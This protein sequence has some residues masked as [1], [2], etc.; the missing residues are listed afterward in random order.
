MTRIGLLA[1]GVPYCI[2]QYNGSSEKRLRFL[3]PFLGGLRRELI[4]N[5]LIGTEPA[6]MELYCGLRVLKAQLKE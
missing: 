2:S 3:D 1:S 6:G 4:N 5:R